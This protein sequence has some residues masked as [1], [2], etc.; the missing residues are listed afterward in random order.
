MIDLYVLN[1]R[2]LRGLCLKLNPNDF[3]ASLTH[4]KD[5]LDAVFGHTKTSFRQDSIS[6]T[7]IFSHGMFFL[8]RNL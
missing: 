3:P 8:A 1:Y 4:R 5:T 7:R 6:L 2:T